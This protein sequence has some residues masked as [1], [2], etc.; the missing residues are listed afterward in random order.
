MACANLSPIAPP[1]TTPLCRRSIVGGCDGS[2]GDWGTR[3]IEPET[4]TPLESWSSPVTASTEPLEAMFM[5][6]WI[7]SLS[8]LPFVDSCA[9]LPILQRSGEKSIL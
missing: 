3:V 6:V 5:E 9:D 8:S 2:R 1:D 4:D 7:V